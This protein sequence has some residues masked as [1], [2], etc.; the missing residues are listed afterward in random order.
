M[1][2]AF[3][4]VLYGLSLSL[5]FVHKRFLLSI[6]ALIPNIHN[7]DEHPSFTKRYALKIVVSTSIWPVIAV[8]LIP[9][10]SSSHLMNCGTSQT[11]TF[12]LPVSHWFR[13]KMG[14][15]IEIS[16]EYIN[17]GKR[18]PASSSSSYSFST[19]HIFPVIWAH[20]GASDLVG[21]MKNICCFRWLCLHILKPYRW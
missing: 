4:T 5:P 2:R 12:H 6:T 18:H 11:R 16:R 20:R 3:L 17:L 1:V 9:L 7:G 13:N 21:A 8:N 15:Y 19:N 10:N 14:I